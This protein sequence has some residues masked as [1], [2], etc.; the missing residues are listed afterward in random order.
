MIARLLCRL[1]FHKWDFKTEIT[2]WMVEDYS[3]CKRE[4]CEFHHPPLLVNRE[5]K[6][7]IR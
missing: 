4:D 3:W 2:P 1:G 5:R 6:K 7:V